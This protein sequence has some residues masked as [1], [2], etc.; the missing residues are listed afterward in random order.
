MGI[1]SISSDFDFF[2]G[3]STVGCLEMTNAVDLMNLILSYLLVERFISHFDF[4]IDRNSGTVYSQ[5]EPA[6]L[7][8]EE[9]LEQLTDVLQANLLINLNDLLSVFEFIVLVKDCFPMA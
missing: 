4:F 6:W 9:V 1:I 8:K 3:V 2:A 5:I 7:F